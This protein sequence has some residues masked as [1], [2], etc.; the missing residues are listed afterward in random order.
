M[1]GTVWGWNRAER[2]FKDRAEQLKKAA[3]QRRK[4]LA[5]EEGKGGGVTPPVV[6]AAGGA[7]SNVDFFGMPYA[8]VPM[9]LP[10]GAGFGMAN[11]EALQKIEQ[12][13]A[14][15]ITRGR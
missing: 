2:R 3:E 5:Q 14:D 8:G 11:P 4:K 7:P 10:G 6:G 1:M 12:Y 13:W 9:G 15:M